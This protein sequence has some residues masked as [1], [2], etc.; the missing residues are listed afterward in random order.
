MNNLIPLTSSAVKTGIFPRGGT[1]KAAQFHLPSGVF[2][3]L[4]TAPWVG[5]EQVE[6]RLGNLQGDFFCCPFGGN[7]TPVDGVQHPMHGFCAHGDWELLTTEESNLTMRFA[8]PGLEI[9]K[10]VWVGEDHPALYQVHTLKGEIKMSYGYHAMLQTGGR[11][12]KWWTSLF[13]HGQV[14]P[15][16]FEGPE[17][18]GRQALR[19][20]A[21]FQNLKF[22][23]GLDGF[24]D[25]TKRP[26]KPGHEDLVQIFA[27]PSQTLSWHA[28]LFPGSPN[29]V[30]VSVRERKNLPGTVVWMSEGG[31]DYAPW[32]GRHTGVLAL[33]DGCTHFH[34]GLAE[35]LAASRSER[36]TFVD[37]SLG[38]VVTRTAMTSLECPFEFSEV[39]DVRVSS[40]SLVL[41][42][43]AGEVETPFEG[44][45]I[46]PGLI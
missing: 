32:S 8:Q 43:D 17:T 21:R 4:H 5:K 30:W 1:L 36:P 44:E 16:V 9:E 12:V 25:L 41:V 23:P 38:P 33:E 27:E 20:G 2:E 10:Q 14:F 26:H 40:E 39:L 15:D 29:R 42:T 31:R 22:V 46:F 7:A 18:N 6:G 45:R 28:A 11:N 3:P 13:A 37:L 19:P 34:Y 24:Y 35:S